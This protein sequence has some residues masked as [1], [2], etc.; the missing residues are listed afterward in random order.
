[1][2]NIN[3]IGSLGLPHIHSTKEIG[4]GS[5]EIR[6]LSVYLFFDAKSGINGAA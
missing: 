2:S 4:S 3:R 5:K 6:K 1:M